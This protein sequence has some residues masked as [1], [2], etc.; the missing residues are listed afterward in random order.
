[1]LNT[2]KIN[3][4]IRMIKERNEVKRT[5]KAWSAVADIISTINSE[6]H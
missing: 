5:V 3:G 6:E 4:K 2:I 1:M